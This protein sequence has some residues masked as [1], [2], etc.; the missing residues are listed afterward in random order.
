MKKIEKYLWHAYRV[1]LRP[2]LPATS[3]VLY[4][5]I[6]VGIDRKSLDSFFPTYKQ[7]YIDIPLYEDALVRAIKTNVRPGDHVTVIGGGYGVTLA[8]AAMAANPRGQVTCFEASASAIGFCRKTLRRNGV[9]EQ[10]TFEHAIVSN[11]YNLYGK[12]HAETVVDPADLI[13]CDVLEL[14]CEGAELN[15]LRGLR[16]RPRA[17][18]V[19]THGVYGSSTAEVS[20][21]LTQMG[22]SVTDLGPAEPRILEKCAEWDLNVLSATLPA[23]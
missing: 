14:D 23:S 1:S 11:S 13:D 16:I 20:D 8:F 18:L 9:E 22:Y 15:I 4:H 10:V 12:G 3:P 5:Q 6:P 2:I 17:I 19:E 7:N 21:L